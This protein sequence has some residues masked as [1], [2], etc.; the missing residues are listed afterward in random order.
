MR[1]G[2]ESMLLCS[3][4]KGVLSVSW[5]SERTTAKKSDRLSPVSCL[6]E[7]SIMYYYADYQ[8]YIAEALE[9][10]VP[11][12]RAAERGTLS[13]TPYISN[14]CSAACRFCSEKLYSGGIVS[15]GLRVCSGYREK[16]TEILCAQRGRNIFLSVSGMEPS[17][18]IE[19]LS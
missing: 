19:Q 11:V 14:H 17:E 12:I 2:T 3:D 13:F 10:S 1:N 5:I 7:G 15:A 9:K 6:S 4:R 8:R 16:L 18:S